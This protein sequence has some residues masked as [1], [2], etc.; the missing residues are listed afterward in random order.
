MK[1]GI[2]TTLLTAMIVTVYL[3]GCSNT[4][5]DKSTKLEKLKAEQ[6]SLSKQI[7]SLEAEIVKENPAAVIV[8]GKEVMVIELAP[9]KFDHYAQTQGSIESEENIMVSAKTMG[10]ITNVLVREGET[11]SKGQTLAQI[12]N[13]LILKGIEEMK[14]QIELTNTIYERQKNLWDQKI[15]TEVQYLQAKTSK[16]SLEKRL[17]SMNEQNEMTKIKS[18]INGVVDAIAAKVG[19]NI[20]PG[21]TAARV[22]NNSELK[23]VAHISESYISNFK[24]GDKILVTF[25]NLKKTV[26]ANLSFVARNIDQLSRTFVVEATL[27][28]SPDFRPNM[29]AVVKVVYFT[30]PAAIVVPVNIVQ[31]VNDESV[32]FVAEADGKNTVARRRVVTVVGVFDNLAQINSGVVA[33]EKIISFGYQGLSDGEV[34]KM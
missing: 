7:A 22:V 21:M 20:S 2:Y 18:P 1:S 4:T 26:E 34:I 33:G 23:I 3:T 16:E 32:V 5:V 11:V 19:Q 6:A 30:D 13:T 28:S 25:P 24:K 8:K 31:T 17:A 15:G 27:P 14:S 12:D 29:T 9:R 10:I